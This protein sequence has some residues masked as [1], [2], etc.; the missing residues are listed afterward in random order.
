M[1]GPER[2][3]E[4]S[5]ECRPSEERFRFRY[6]SGDSTNALCVWDSL[7]ALLLRERERERER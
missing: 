7:S 6:V 4:L 1:E 2:R 3:Y 5:D